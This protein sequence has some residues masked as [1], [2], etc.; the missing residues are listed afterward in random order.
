VPIPIASPYKLVRYRSPAGEL[1]A[2]IT[3]DRKDGEK[4][5]AVVWCH[6]GFGGIDASYWAEQPAANDQTPKAFV[7]AGFVVM[8]PAWRGENENPG[9]FEMFLGESDDALAAVDYVRALPYVDA[10]R[11]YLVGHS[12]GGTVALLAAMTDGAEKKVRAAVSFGGVLDCREMRNG[13]GHMIPFDPADE[14]E[15][16]V[17]SPIEFVGALRVP[18]LYIEGELAAAGPLVPRLAQ[19]ARDA[20]VPLAAYVVREGDHFDILRPLTKLLAQRL[21]R[22]TNPRTDVHLDAKSI[23]D[24][25]EAEHAERLRKRRALPVVTLKPAAAAEMKAVMKQKGL[26][27]DK[28]WLTIDAATGKLGLSD[29]FDKATQV[30]LTQE[31]V[32]IAVPKSAAERG[33]GLVIDFRDDAEGKGFS[34]SRREE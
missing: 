6:G 8:I 29:K 31:G 20:R 24:A 25:F 13:W 28:T 15:M 4:R 30:E 5:P 32:K 17:R 7:D 14:Q 11:V 18:T 27:P 1:V 21:L 34:F 2:L 16:R 9:N 33:R 22:D 23:Q 10:K 12:S 26:S 3:P 19:S